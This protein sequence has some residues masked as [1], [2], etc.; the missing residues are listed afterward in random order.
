MVVVDRLTKYAHFIALSHLFTAAD[1]AHSFFE[2]VFKYHGLPITMV[3]DRDPL[4]LSQFWVQ[5]FKL[6]GTKLLHSSAYHPQTDGQ[7]E[8]VNQCLETFLRCMTSYKPTKWALWLHMAQWWYNTNYHTALKM[9]PFE[10]L[11]GYKPPSGI[12]PQHN[13]G[14]VTIVTDFV[15]ERADMQLVIK[16]HLLQAQERTKMYADRK[17]TER[18]FEAGDFVYL[19]LQPYRQMTVTLRRNLKLAPK[20]FGPYKIVKRIGKVAYQL[21][22]PAGSRIHSVFHVSQLKKQVGQTVVP[23]PELPKVGPEGQFL[24]EPIAVLDRRMVKRNN[25]PMA[26][27]LVQW[28]HTHPNDATW[29]DYP[30]L[31][32]QF[33]NFCPLRTRSC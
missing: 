31:H 30:V 33:P 2:N 25:A 1:I 5:L 15:K 10:A 12:F 18:E 21:D 20:F 28:S 6:M 13:Y 14:G 17:R 27:W 29:E 8:R 19:R 23:S 9:T 24:V 4:F 32:A 3:S 26:Q 16:D 7:T 22:L 11:H